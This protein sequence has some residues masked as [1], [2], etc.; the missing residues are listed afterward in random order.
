MLS[1]SCLVSLQVRCNC[2][3]LPAATSNTGIWLHMVWQK[4]SAS[5]NHKPHFRDFKMQK[6][7]NPWWP[8][9]HD[10]IWY[11]VWLKTFHYWTLFGHPIE[12][13]VKNDIG[14]PCFV[15]PYVLATLTQC[16]RCDYRALQQKLSNLPV[17]GLQH[18]DCRQANT[19]LA[20]KSFLQSIRSWS[21][22]QK[23]TNGQYISTGQPCITHQSLTGG[24]T[25]WQPKQFISFAL[26]VT[27][28][29]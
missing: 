3:F 9:T 24:K 20:C 1:M 27:W 6:A 26:H 19:C 15:K 18:E 22:Q 21:V 23:K 13:F 10:Q 8:K 4:P 28:E 16:C 7:F 17:L 25:C 14:W 29:V 12:Q 2:G 5:T 11:V